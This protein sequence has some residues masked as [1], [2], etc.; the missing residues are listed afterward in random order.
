M[1]SGE[2]NIGFLNLHLLH[3][4]TQWELSEQHG[5]YFLKNSVT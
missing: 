5:K 2:L 1:N 4:G 3:G